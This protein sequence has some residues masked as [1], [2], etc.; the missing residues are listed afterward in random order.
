MTSSPPSRIL[1]FALILLFLGFIGL[2]L[3]LVSCAKK[4]PNLLLITIDTLRRDALGI[5]SP[6]VWWTPTMDSIAGSGTVWDEAR[7]PF[8]LTQPSHAT[9]MTG[10]YPAEHGVCSNRSCLQDAFSSL[11]EELSIEGYQCG[12]FIN[13][14]VLDRGAG[15]G[16]GFSLFTRAEKESLLAPVRIREKGDRL[17]WWRI[18]P[19]AGR[20]VDMALGWLSDAHEPF[21]LWL[22]LMDPHLDYAPPDSALQILGAPDIPSELGSREYIRDREDSN[23]PLTELEISQV[24]LLYAGEVAYVDMAL[25]DLFH[26]IR[27]S[28]KSSRTVIVLV[29][30][31]GESIFDDGRYVGH[32]YSLDESVVR[33]PLVL[34]G[35]HI[36]RET[37]IQAPVGLVQLKPTLLDLLGVAPAKEAV[38]GLF[39]NTDRVQITGDIKGRMLAHWRGWECVWSEG[40]K[41]PEQI[42]RGDADSMLAAS[43]MD[44]VY[45]ALIDISRRP[46]SRSLGQHDIEEL[47]A[48]AQ[49]H[50][51][52]AN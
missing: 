38:P 47:Q 3:P 21:F 15:F 25:R 50:L 16:Q 22:H 44:S 12:A 27:R 18:N 51:C 36:P 23:Q 11:A 26:G 40:K 45:E 43:V 20:S 7:A 32:A 17:V 28:N 42:A 35:Y 46:V 1:A 2:A 24:R 13:T 19:K 10:L 6:D 37:R 8:T 49:V 5:Y 31:H 52:F 41:Q 14:W 34:T 33:I 29:S 4:Q 30:D 39:S 9:M 48:L